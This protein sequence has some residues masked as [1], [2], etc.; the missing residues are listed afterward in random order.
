MIKAALI[1]LD[2]L[3]INSEELYLEANKIYFK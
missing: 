3:L 1:G 2:G